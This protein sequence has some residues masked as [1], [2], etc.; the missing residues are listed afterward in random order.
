M[1]LLL[2][3]ILVISQSLLAEEVIDVSKTDFNGK[4]FGKRSYWFVGEQ[5]IAEISSKE[6]QDSFQLGENEQHSFKMNKPVFWVKVS[7][8]NP[9]PASQ[10]IY[11]FD[12]SNFTEQL[13]VYRHAKFIEQLTHNETL[14]ERVIELDLP[15]NELTTLYIKKLSKGSQRQS[16]TYWK[17]E[18]KLIAE[19]KNSERNWSL[20][21]AVFAMSLLFNVMVWLAY[22]SKAYIYYLGYIITISSYAT[23]I[24][25]MIEGPY[26]AQLLMGSVLVAEIF[27]F[28]FTIEFLSLKRGF[29]KSYLTIMIF[30]MCVTLL[31]PLVFTNLFFVVRA[32][33]TLIG[34]SSIVCCFISL[35]VFLKTR[36]VHV[37]IYTT[38]Y[39]TML[40][41][42]VVQNLIWGGS[43]PGL[44]GHDYVGLYATAAEN[45]L[46][47]MAMGYKIYGTQVEKRHSYAQLAKVFYP[48][49]ISQI[50]SGRNLE[51]TMPIGEAEAYV[52]NFDIVG[53][54]EIMHESFSEL[55][56]EFM[57]KC[58]NMMMDGYDESSLTS[59]GYMI[60]EMGDG[61]LC[62]VGYPFKQTGDL[63]S[64]CAVHL[65]ETMIEQ[66]TVMFAK[67]M[68][69]NPIY[70]CTGIAMGTVKSYFS[71]SGRIRDDLWGL[72]V[73]LATRYESTRK[74]IIDRLD[75]EPSSLVILQEDVYKS[76]PDEEKNGYTLIDLQQT[77][78]VIRD[79]PS[80]KRLAFK[81]FL[82]HEGEKDIPQAS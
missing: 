62:S 33:M 30:I 52:I 6:F 9:T 81:Q 68:A 56:E 59:A 67:R 65:A 1:K 39:G 34:L 44:V 40:A 74:R 32:N 54:T 35:I 19:I 13:I 24:W 16:W 11:I 28:L 20:V 10:K 82:F 4:G 31:L 48:H 3:V 42:N 38:A 66:F 72:P 60:K 55:V 2:F 26:L 75:L 17:S 69:S 50:R 77:G 73:V 57:G 45:I 51:D 5:D 46:M 63:K 71:K 76:L 64:V 58:R 79:D 29:R 23:C 14:S 80:A 22:R 47:L 15:A 12:T 70:C 49:Q 36:K 18:K 8:L 7:F 25:S 43:I 21:M 61:F 78:I 37:L 27:G 53:S 41:G